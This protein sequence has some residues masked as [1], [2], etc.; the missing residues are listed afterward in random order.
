MMAMDRYTKV[1]LTVIAVALVMLALNPWLKP[2]E[3][4]MADVVGRA[5]AQNPPATTEPATP[6]APAAPPAAQPEAAPAPGPTPAPGTPAPGAPAGP[7][8]PRGGPM[9][10]RAGGPPAQRFDDCTAVAS[11]TLPAAWGR[12]AALGPGLFLFE[13]EDMLRFVRTAPYETAPPGPNGRPCRVLEIKK[14][15]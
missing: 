6:A 7:G 13:S 1:V 3:W 9:G 14:V 10:P 12:V 2:G 4:R 8:R 11:E 5:E 15:K